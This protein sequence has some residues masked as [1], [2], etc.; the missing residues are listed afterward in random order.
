[1]DRD[2]TMDAFYQFKCGKT[3]VEREKFLAGNSAGRKRKE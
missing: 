2:R 3:Q 1:M